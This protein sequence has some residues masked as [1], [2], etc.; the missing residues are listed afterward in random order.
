MD[1]TGKKVSHFKYGLG[2]IT[3]LYPDNMIIWVRFGTQSPK[4]YKITDD[5]DNGTLTAVDEEVKHFIN[6]YK[7]FIRYRLHG[8]ITGQQQT[9][10]KDI[11]VFFKNSCD[12]LDDLGIKYGNVTAV[13][14][15]PASVTPYAQC[16]ALNNGNFEIEICADYLT[17]DTCDRFVYVLMLHEL[18]H[19]CEGGIKHNR[20]Y[21]N[22][23][24][25]I[26]RF[27]GYSTR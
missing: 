7:N 11:T 19:T 23:A 12:I 3:A 6:D 1:I 16:L 24:G 17:D 15:V 20:K 8:R 2:T 10:N 4:L 21:R 25:I 26:E 27:Y 14:T 13:R 9:K 18:I 5:F 22:Y